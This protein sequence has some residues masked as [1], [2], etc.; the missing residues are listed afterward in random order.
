MADSGER[1][2]RLKVL[3][4]VVGEGGFEP[5]TACPQSRCATTAPLPGLVTVPPRTAAN[6]GVVP[7]GSRGSSGGGPVPER[8]LDAHAG[9][10]SRRGAEGDPAAVRLDRGL[11][12]R[13]PEPRA[14]PVAGAGRV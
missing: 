4:T 9:A 7:G 14:A 12:D 6:C 5:P 3:V 11:H 13:E 8:Q 1:F 2:Q 10:G